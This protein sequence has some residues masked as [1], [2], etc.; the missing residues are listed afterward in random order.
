MLVAGIAALVGSVASSASASV[1]C[2]KKSGAVF[3][4][5]ACKK[6][7]TPLDVSGLGLVGPQGP[8]G[9]IGMPGQKGD[10]GTPAAAFWVRVHYDGTIEGA[11]DPG[12]SVS[13][14]LTGIY[15]ITFPK[16]VSACAP[17]VSVHDTLDLLGTPTIN[18]GNVPGPTEVD[19]TLRA[20]NPA[21]SAGSYD[22]D[23]SLALACP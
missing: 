12:I 7:E 1:L 23:F 17:V 21:G 10:P 20:T 4:R 13:H 14:S 22:G 9:M 3:V 5:S 6:K 16:D 11:S 15:E 19:V 18:V 8:P 2:Q